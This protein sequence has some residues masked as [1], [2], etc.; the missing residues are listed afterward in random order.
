MAGAEQPRAEVGERGGGE[1]AV[2]ELLRVGGAP[3]DGRC[4]GL[5]SE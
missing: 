4:T 3:E 1:V 2:E 5:V